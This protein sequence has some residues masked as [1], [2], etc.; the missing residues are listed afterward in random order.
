M[1]YDHEVEKLA[2]R[3]REDALSGYKWNV[4]PRFEDAADMAKEAWRSRAR[5]QLSLAGIFPPALKPLGQ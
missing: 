5:H 1:N 4:P 3:I 2:S